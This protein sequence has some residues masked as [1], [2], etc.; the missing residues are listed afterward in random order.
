MDGVEVTAMEADLLESMSADRDRHAGL[1]PDGAGNSI[2]SI[3][4]SS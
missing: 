3:G 2:R 4:G 1:W